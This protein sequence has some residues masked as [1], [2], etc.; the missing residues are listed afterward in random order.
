MPVQ[1]RPKCNEPGRLLVDASTQAY[2]YYFRCD[3]C[4]HVWTRQKHDPAAP[5]RS[6]TKTPQPEQ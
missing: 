3:K 6:I 5:P 1:R 2:V 4:G